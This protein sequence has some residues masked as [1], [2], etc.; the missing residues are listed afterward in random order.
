MTFH[1][2]QDHLSEKRRF[3]FLFTLIFRLERTIAFQD[4]HSGLVSEGQC[5]ANQ[6]AEA[7]M[8]WWPQEEQ[9]QEQLQELLQEG[10][11]FNRTYSEAHSCLSESLMEGK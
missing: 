2:Q 10:T 5:I 6:V 3:P 1:F 11:A 4:A 8:Y 7:A 9:L